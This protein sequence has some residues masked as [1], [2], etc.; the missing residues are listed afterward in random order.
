M[1]NI[2][3]H[4][5]RDKETKRFFRFARN[6]PDKDF[7]GKKGRYLRGDFQRFQKFLDYIKPFDPKCFLVAEENNRFLGFIVVVYNPVWISE[8]VE[9]YGYDIGKRAYILGIAVVQRRKDVFKALTDEMM[10]Y[11]SAREIEGAEYPTLGNICLTTGTDVLTSENVDPLIIFREAGFRISE[12]YYSMK[13]DLNACNS[14]E[15]CSAEDV[16]FRSKR[17]SIEA[18]KG[19]EVFGKITWDPIKNEKTSIEIH[20]SQ[21]YRRKGLGSALMAR[22]LQKLKADGVKTVELGVDGNNLSAL[23]LYRKFGFTVSKTHF[24]ILMPFK[25][26]IASHLVIQLSSRGEL[27]A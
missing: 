4:S 24:Y 7:W 23:R 16:G 6:L 20:V 26:K 3:V 15:E 8:L 18:F 10:T 21:G 9:R 13:V 14:K 12:C 22:T 17:K 11:F 19:N 27:L 2:I 1:K 5:L 25:S